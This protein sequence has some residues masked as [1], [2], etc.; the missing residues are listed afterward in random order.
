MPRSS[1]LWITFRVASRSMRPPKLLQPRPMAETRRPDAPRLRI[2]N[3]VVLVQKAGSEG[4]Q[5]GDILAAFR[6]LVK[7]ERRPKRHNAGRVDP[8]V[9]LVIVPLDVG[10]VHR[11]RDPG[12]LV[13]V[14]RVRPEVLV[15]D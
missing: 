5:A 10:E 2:S 15:V 6:R 3:G 8:L 7:I 1:A 14:A 9:A 11:R 12:H 13:D 4:Q